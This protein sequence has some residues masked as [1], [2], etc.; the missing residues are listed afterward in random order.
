MIML[1][2]HYACNLASLFFFMK[3]ASIQI[4]AAANFFSVNDLPDDLDPDELLKT[5][6]F[7]IEP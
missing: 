1:C 6:D 5:Q 2:S 7:D 3:A 4:S